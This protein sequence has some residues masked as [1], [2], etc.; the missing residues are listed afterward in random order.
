MGYRQFLVSR[1]CALRREI[2]IVKVNIP[3]FDRITI[4]EA[5]GGLCAE[6]IHC[7]RTGKLVTDWICNKSNRKK[8]SMTECDSFEPDSFAK[9]H[10][11]MRY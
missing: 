10:W 1:V 8:V 4:L 5:E 2:I 9:S 6:C 11:R 7:I 3:D